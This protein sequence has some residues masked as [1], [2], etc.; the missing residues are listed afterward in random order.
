MNIQDIQ[1]SLGSF[2]SN[3]SDE[4]NNL[5]DKIGTMRS[6]I[7]EGLTAP[8]VISG[9]SGGSKELGK[10]TSRGGKALLKRAD[11]MKKQNIL[12]RKKLTDIQ[13]RPAPEKT[14]EPEPEPEQPMVRNTNVRPT[15]VEL[16]PT[17]IDRQARPSTDTPDLENRPSNALSESK[18][19]KNQTADITPEVK[20]PT[21]LSNLA[22][23]SVKL[24]GEDTEKTLRAVGSGL[25][26]VGETQI[27][28]V[29]EVADIGAGVLGGYELIHSFT[30]G[31]KIEELQQQ[32]E[33]LESQT[34]TDSIVTGG[35][36]SQVKNYSAPLNF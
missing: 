31:H 6:N 11:A 28:I 25:T 36:Q 15:N 10:L 1:S 2:R 35:N 30:K 3:V 27:P 14:P 18:I 24:A 5:N 29:S 22:G 7:S 17:K 13:S 8:M 19:P 33:K 32:K 20:E 9:I 23:D 21:K 16:Q 34:P 12:D 26:D 4:V